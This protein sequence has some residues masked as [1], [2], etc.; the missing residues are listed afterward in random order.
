MKKRS[1]RD[2]QKAPGTAVVRYQDAGVSI[3]EAERGVGYIKELVRGATSKSVLTGIGSF[4]GGFHLKGWKDPV[5]IS[6]IDGAGT[7]VKVAVM[8]NRHT[9]IGQD[10]VNHCVNDIMVQ[11]ATPLFFLDYFATGKLQAE[12]LKDVVSG[13]ATACAEN[14]CALI[15]GETAEM[16]GMYGDDDYD[17]A[18]CIIG[19]VEKKRLLTGLKV[20]AGDVLFGLPSTGLH[21]NGYSL[22]R[23]LLFEVAGY[24]VDTVVEELGC[25][26]AD[27]LLKVHRSY[28]KPLSALHE[29]GLLKAAAHIT[30]GGITDNL[31]R[32]L[33]KGTVAEISTGSW[34]ELPIFPLLKKLGNMPDDDYRRTFNTGI[35]M[36]FVVSERKASKAEKLL[37]Q[38]KETAYWIGRIEDGKSK[39]RVLYR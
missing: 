21:T 15:G 9:T 19:A 35:G 20:K 7:K 14:Q 6:S 22:A 26:V 10:L 34:P 25:S 38:L 36:I 3:D 24:T 18:G 39:T 33:P 13:M 23:K 2:L 32:V 27:E 17:I 37:K 29:A 8:A 11:G 5:L 4:G 30:G 28:R 16:P 1:N 12:T 31:P